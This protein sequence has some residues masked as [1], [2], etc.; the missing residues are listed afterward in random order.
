MTV[1]AS[2]YYLADGVAPYLIK[3]SD[4]TGTYAVISV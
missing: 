1:K 3:S 4:A 2:F